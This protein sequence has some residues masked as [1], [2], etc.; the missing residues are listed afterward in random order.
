MKSIKPHIRISSENNKTVLQVDTWELKDYV[1]DYLTEKCGIEYEYFEEVNPDLKQT[2]RETYYLYYTLQYSLDKIEEAVQKLDEKEITEIVR[3]QRIQADGKFYCPCCG[4][5]TLSEPPKGTHNICEVCFWEDDRTQL[6]DPSYEG[7]ANRVSLI[8]AQKNF[9]LFGACDKEMVQN[10]SNP[11]RNAI[12]NPE[13]K[14][15]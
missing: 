8:Q 13:W 10:V 9:E 1:E 11:S 14:I 7:G 5:N 6:E 12:R 15:S 3:F 4:Y 2:N